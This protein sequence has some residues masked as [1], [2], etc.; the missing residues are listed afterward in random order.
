MCD[1]ERGAPF[2]HSKGAV[3]SQ[4]DVVFQSERERG[5]GMG[6]TL[7]RFVACRGK[8]KTVRARRTTR[9][10]R[11]ST[12]DRRVVYTHLRRVYVRV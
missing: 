10:S 5:T 12:R 8:K 1:M 3:S 7:V 11:A 2:P 4:P 6:E 9:S